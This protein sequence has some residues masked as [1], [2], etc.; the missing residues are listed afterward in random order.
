MQVKIQFLRQNV[1]FLTDR[2]GWH[3]LTAAPEKQKKEGKGMARLF[4]RKWRRKNESAISRYGM[5]YGE[6]C[7]TRKRTIGQ[8]V[9]L[10]EKDRKEKKRKERE[11]AKKR[12]IEAFNAIFQRR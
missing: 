5:P 4:L 12:F 11:A 8:I 3:I 6:L 1:N 2:N 10:E 7:P 9:R